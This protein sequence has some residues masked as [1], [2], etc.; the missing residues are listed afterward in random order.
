M[1]PRAPHS[2]HG[3]CAIEKSRLAVTLSRARRSRKASRFAGADTAQRNQS[4]GKECLEAALNRKRQSH[5]RISI[6]IHTYIHTYIHIYYIYI[7]M[8]VGV[9]R[10]G[11]GNRDV[12]KLKK[13][14]IFRKA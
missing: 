3:Q 14:E 13:S 6:Y 7:Y 11:R 5:M 2:N 10:I 9:A 8:Q 4:G 1:A 12:G